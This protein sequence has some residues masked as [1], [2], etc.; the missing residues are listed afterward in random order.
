ML[1]RSVDKA[2]ALAAANRVNEELCAEGFVLLKNDG[3]LPLPGGARVSVFGMNSAD[4]VYGGSG[5]GAKENSNGVDIYMSLESAGFQ[6]NPELKEFYAAQKAAG[7]GRTSKL[8]FD[9][10]VLEGLETGEL[11]LSDYTGGIQGYAGDYTDAALVVFSRVGGEGYDLPR[12]MKNTAGANP[13]DHYLQLD[14]NERALL[15]ALCA[16]DSG[17]GSVVVILNSAAPMELGFLEDGV[18]NGKLKGCV[19]VGTTGGT[20]MAALGR[21]LSG[22]VNPSGRLVDTFARRFADA[23]AWANF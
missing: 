5:S 13:E 6:V 15:E 9:T 20:G 8:N 16:P 23:P 11:P 21:L 19:W 2:T 1:F 7:K 18:Y 22:E 12:T 14:N 3:A 4:P 17:F 10:G